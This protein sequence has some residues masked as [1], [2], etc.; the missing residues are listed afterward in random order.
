MV[1]TT[2]RDFLPGTST[3][4]TV[5]AVQNVRKDSQN[6]LDG[7]LNE[8]LNGSVSRG[9]GKVSDGAMYRTDDSDVERSAF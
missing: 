7:S 2:M 5:G 3:V 6:V 8:N 1:A 9:Y 4:T